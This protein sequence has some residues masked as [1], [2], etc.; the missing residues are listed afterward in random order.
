MECS[1][2][3]KI[4]MVLKLL[5]LKQQPI[6]HWCACLVAQSC[7]TLCNPVECSPPAFSIFSRGNARPGCHLLLQRLFP[8][9]ELNP[10]HLYLLHCRG[11]LYLLS[12]KGSPYIDNKATKNW[13]RVFNSKLWASSGITHYSPANTKVSKCWLPASKDLFYLP[14]TLTI[15][16]LDSHFCNL[17]P[18][19]ISIS[20]GNSH[21]FS[22]LF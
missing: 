4:K 18:F 14:P 6:Y 20:Q 10:H 17:I 2:I 12:H 5:L 22:S 15:L 1:D 3:L 9:H 11:I 13:S 19:M 16:S 8:T 21:V 7:Q